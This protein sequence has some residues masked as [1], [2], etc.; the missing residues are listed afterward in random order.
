MTDYHVVETQTQLKVSK[1][2]AKSARSDAHSKCRPDGRARSS[3]QNGKLSRVDF[4]LTLVEITE[5]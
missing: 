4:E 3:P 5:S 1:T 2:E